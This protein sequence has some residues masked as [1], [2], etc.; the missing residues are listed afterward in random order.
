[1]ATADLTIYLDEVHLHLVAA[2][3]LLQ[4]AKQTA[5]TGNRALA[6]VRAGL[7]RKV[8]QAGADLVPVLSSVVE[9]SHGARILAQLERE[10]KF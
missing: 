4:S 8:E 9:L 2:A 5:W 6:K 1:M 10:A 7:F 3:D